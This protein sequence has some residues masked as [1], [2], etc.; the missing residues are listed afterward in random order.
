MS[1]IQ[2]W[3]LYFGFKALAEQQEAIGHA[4][5]DQQQRMMTARQRRDIEERLWDYSAR[6]HLRLAEE[7]PELDKKRVA[8]VATQ[9]AVE[10]LELD[11]LETADPSSN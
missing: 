10:L 11:K 8:R 6:L 3:G 7:L 2:Y 1:I 4:L 9:L 5:F